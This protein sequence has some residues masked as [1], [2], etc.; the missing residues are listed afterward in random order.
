MTTGMIALIV[1]GII[2]LIA[3]V[4]ALTIGI[5][6]Y[7]YNSKNTRDIRKDWGIKNKKD[8]ELEKD[9]DKIEY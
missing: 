5:L 3:G 7:I 9:E 8:K 4:S 6:H 2:I 1:I